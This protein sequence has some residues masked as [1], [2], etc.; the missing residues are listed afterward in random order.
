MDFDSYMEAQMN[1]RVIGI[2][3]N[4]GA[5]YTGTE[6]GPK[7]FREAH[8]IEKLSKKNLIFDLGDL[9]I[10]NISIRHNIGAIRNWPAPKM[11]WDKIMDHNNI[12]VQ[13]DF[14]IV[15]GGGCSAFTGVFMNFH[16]FYGDQAQ[17]LSIDHHIDMK[18]PSP[19]ICIGATAFTLY[20]LTHKNQWVKSI[21]GFDNKKITSMGF[22]PKTL[23][24]TYS[25]EG[26]RKYDKHILEDKPRQ[27]AE[28]YL[29]NLDADAKVLLHFDLDAISA[30]EITSVYM[31]SPDGLRL[32]TIATLLKVICKDKRIVGMVLTEYS[33]SLDSSE[34][35][36]KIVQFL[37]EIFI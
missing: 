27:V 15:L 20:F 10:D 22:N 31:P 4:V 13:G 32:K 9:D 25:T 21:D 29:K 14:T 18:V 5:L 19:D 3:S 34:D 37:E 24:A 1:I 16:K 11:M 33:P 30:D 35:A 7:A 12:F 2:P 8:I 28:D 26:V 6:L 36:S 23:D 17:I